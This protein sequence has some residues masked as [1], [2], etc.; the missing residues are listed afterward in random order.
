MSGSQETYASPAAVGR[1]IRAV[2][3]AGLQLGSIKLHRDGAIELIHSD[4][5]VP[6]PVNDFDRLDAAGCL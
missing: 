1:A 2:Q 6:V 3:K 4:L 5:A